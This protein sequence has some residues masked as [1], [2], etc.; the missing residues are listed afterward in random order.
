MTRQPHT[1]TP[2]TTEVAAAKAAAKTADFR[3][4]LEDRIAHDPRSLHAIEVEA[5]IPGNALGKFIRGERG[6]RHSLTPRLIQRLA[7]VIRVGEIE[8]L[9]RAGH[10]TYEPRCEPLESAILATRSLDDEAKLLMLAFYGRLAAPATG[11][12]A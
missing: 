11:H 3:V 12:E 2:V 4:W 5:G 7:P 9:V 1:N 8:L 10:L 6:G